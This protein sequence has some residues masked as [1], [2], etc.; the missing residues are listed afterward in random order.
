M[1]RGFL[2]CWTQRRL[3]PLQSLGLLPASQMQERTSAGQVQSNRQLFAP[4]PRHHKWGP[5]VSEFSAYAKLMVPLRAPCTD[6]HLLTPYPK[7]SKIIHRRVV[8]RGEKR[9][10][11]AIVLAKDGL[12]TAVF[13]HDNRLVS[14]EGVEVVSVG[15]PREP[16]EVIREAWQKGHPRSFLLQLDQDMRDVVKLN[17]RET[18][19]NLANL[20][21]EFIK[22]WMRRALELQDHQAVR[23]SKR[24]SHLSL[25]LKGKKSPRS[26]IRSHGFSERVLADLSGAGIPGSQRP[27]NC[28]L[29]LL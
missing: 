2:R 27:R 7:G 29:V 25:L 18:T 11:D 3:C 22:K 12:L 5:L 20:R 6:A 16:C 14:P 23:D 28:M 13:D 21:I 15:I 24:P 1:S 9:P 10:D 17:L 4:Q 19:E 26:S 8:H